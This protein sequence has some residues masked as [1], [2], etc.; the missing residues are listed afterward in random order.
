MKTRQ[1]TQCF[2]QGM[3]KGARDVVEAI[4]G[5][6]TKRNEEK[7]SVTSLSS[8]SQFEAFN[9]A[10]TP[11]PP[12]KMFISKLQPHIARP[13]VLQAHNVAQLEKVID[14]ALRIEHSFI[15][16][17]SQTPSQ[18]D[19]SFTTTLAVEC[20]HKQTDNPQNFILGHLRPI[21][22][23]DLQVH[24]DAAENTTNILSESWMCRANGEAVLS[25]TDV[26]HP[27]AT[28][29]SS[30]Q[31]YKIAEQQKE[32][33]AAELDSSVL[34][35]FTENLSELNEH[36]NEFVPFTTTPLEPFSEQVKPPRRGKSMRKLTENSFLSFQL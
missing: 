16:S 18:Q 19:S 7:R 14:A 33:A 22:D 8:T 4:F 15:T 25:P 11:P 31:T 12:Q 17:E 20:K 28:S 10:L 2:L 26:P 9:T 5:E 21:L 36:D 1:V 32:L 34:S 24:E 13:L 30:S 35:P 6:A 29:I 23:E 3:R 27:T